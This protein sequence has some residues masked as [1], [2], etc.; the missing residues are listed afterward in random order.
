MCKTL[1]IRVAL[2]TFVFCMLA[3]FWGKVASPGGSVSSLSDEELAQLTGGQS[4]AWCRPYFDC[5]S[6]VHGVAPACTESGVADCTNKDP[7]DPCKNQDGQTIF[8]FVFYSPE[9]CH[10]DFGNETCSTW[11]DTHVLCRRNYTCVC[12]LNG[13]GNM[14]CLNQTLT[15]V[16]CA[17][18]YTF[19]SSVPV[20]SVSSINQLAVD[21][22]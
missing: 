9:A 19:L 11:S 5:D 7:G 18:I 21:C 1:A 13:V 17:R 3:L 4:P 22:L 15:G 16:G 2:S 6:A 20:S 8:R 12:G 14:V 10:T